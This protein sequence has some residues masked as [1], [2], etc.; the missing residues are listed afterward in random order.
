MR[1]RVL[2]GRKNWSFRYSIDQIYRKVDLPSPTY[3]FLLDS[4]LCRRARC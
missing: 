1:E 2:G 3:I 4:V